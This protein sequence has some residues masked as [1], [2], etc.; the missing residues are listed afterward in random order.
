MATVTS[1][2]SVSGEYIGNISMQYT[3][4]PFFVGEFSPDIIFAPADLDNPIPLGYDAPVN[5]PSDPIES[6]A[7]GVLTVNQTGRYK[8]EALPAL[9]KGG[10][11]GQVK[12]VFRE[13]HTRSAVV[14]DTD[15]LLA[16]LNPNSHVQTNPIFYDR[17]LMAQDNLQYF[18]WPD[19]T[20]GSNGGL[21][22]D[23]ITLGAQ[24]KPSWCLSIQRIWRTYP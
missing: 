18:I 22:G 14:T 21:V 13:R 19:S 6:T 12:F 15:I 3:S 17:I 10:A 24:S 8:I 1:P 11:A 9:S 4:D 7:G 2:D 16:T 23:V 5:G 20:N